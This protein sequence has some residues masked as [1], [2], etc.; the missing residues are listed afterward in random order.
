MSNG[1]HP[2]STIDRQ[3]IKANVLGAIINAIAGFLSYGLG[4]LLG[5]SED[6]DRGIGFVIYVVLVVLSNTFSVVLYGFLLGVV[7]RQKLPAFPMRNW[8]ALYAVFGI[9]FGA[10]TVYGSLRPQGVEPSGPAIELT[11]DLMI[12]AFI[13]GSMVGALGGAMQALILHPAARGLGAWIGFSAIADAAVI[14]LIVITASP[15]LAGGLA[16][17]LIGEATLF[18]GCVLAAFI[19]LPAVQRLQP[20]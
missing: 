17:E 12:G 16:G 11:R 5:V 18:A 13:G 3:W 8:V 15:D 19:M 4:Q 1:P 7:L 9:M 2:R 20:R 6:G 10:L 14:T